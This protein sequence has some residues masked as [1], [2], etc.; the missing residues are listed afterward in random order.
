MGDTPNTFADAIARICPRFRPT[1]PVRHSDTSAL[2]P[3]R[4]GGVPVMAKRP[5]DLRPFWLDRC[6]HEITVYQAMQADPPA[7]R[8]PELVAADPDEPL[9][10]VTMLDGR[11]LH[12]L[13]YQ[14]GT[15]SARDIDTLLDLLSAL[16]AWRPDGVPRDDDY[17][18]QLR[19]LDNPV[20]RERH[21]RMLAELL[22]RAA[23]PLQVEHGDAHLANALTGRGGPALID[24]E[25][26]AWRP[27]GY[28]LAKVWLF[29]GPAADR[30]RVLARL[31]DDLGLHAGFWIS[32][33]IAL[34][35]EIISQRRPPTPPAASP[36]CGACTPISPTRSDTP[37]TWPGCWPDVKEIP[38]TQ[39]LCPD[40]IVFDL[41]DLLIAT[42]GSWG[43]AYA[44]LFSAHGVHLSD[45]DR[46][47]L[48]TTPFRQLGDALAA[49]L[50]TT[51]PTKVLIEQLT[52]A[53]ADNGGQPV[54]T[55]PGA[56]ELVPALAVSYPLAVATNS[57]TAVAVHHLT[58]L[59]LIRFFTAIAGFDQVDRPKP[60]PDLYALAARDLRVRPARAI[61]LD[62][63]QIGLDSASAARFG[64][65]IG[66]S[67]EGQRLRADAVFGSLADP[68]LWRL[69][70]V[71]PAHH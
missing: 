43:R 35:R 42:S 16:H 23:P 44:A 31:G 57:P 3:G 29:I 8:T 47:R 62:D 38:V 46:R 51:A 19:R 6:R 26:T 17:P 14:S 55:M 70:G 61:A 52:L 71:A 59:G 40:G 15:V 10:I 65:V 37:P 67:H 60:A 32:A 18:A 2:W 56:A 33:V 13:R 30:R 64:Y 36:G 41:D 1:G 34:S 12:P 53:L 20:L 68:L 48:K 54:R 11:P 4:V 5:T 7:V 27:A 58:N 63:S 69:L 50:G 24:F 39:P 25:F 66:I 22:E 9:V 28:D 45:A 49:L 21:L